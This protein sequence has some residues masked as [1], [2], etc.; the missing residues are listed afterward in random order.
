MEK[1]IAEQKYL[2]LNLL[3]EVTLKNCH[4]H[5]RKYW[6]KFW[7]VTLYQGKD[8]WHLLLQAIYRE[9]F[10]LYY[11][12]GT[13]KLRPKKSMPFL[14]SLLFRTWKCDT[15]SVRHADT[16]LKCSTIINPGL[17]PVQVRGKEQSAN[18][19]ARRYPFPSRTFG[20]GVTLTLCASLNPTESEHSSIPANPICTVHY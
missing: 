13:V 5:Q 9:I 20:M 14:L 6:A 15:P 2:L 4:N 7:Q 3:K 12:E 10:L 8:S 16:R 18:L 11:A 19:S 17:P 1:W